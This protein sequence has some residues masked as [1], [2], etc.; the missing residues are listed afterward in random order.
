MTFDTKAF[1]EAIAGLPDVKLAHLAKSIIQHHHAG[2]RAS[3]MMVP[4]WLL[5]EECERRQPS[6]QSSKHGQRWHLKAGLWSRCMKA[7]VIK[8]EPDREA[9]DEFLGEW[10]TQRAPA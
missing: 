3:E 7:R 5:F 4:W 10:S 1:A 8:W 9:T 2:Y 6:A